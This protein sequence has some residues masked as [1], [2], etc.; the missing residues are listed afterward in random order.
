M[1]N[2]EKLNAG[3]SFYKRSFVEEVRKCDDLSRVLRQIAEEYE[4][5]GIPMADKD[6]RLSL[7]LSLED[8]EDKIRSV[9]DELSGLKSTQEVR[10]QHVT[11][12]PYATTTVGR[13]A[14]L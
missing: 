1:H 11:P 9:D 2:R 13:E 6:D 4:E 8:V 14:A 12:P 7:S 10:A 3:T 5:S